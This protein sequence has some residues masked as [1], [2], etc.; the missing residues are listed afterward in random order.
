MLHIQLKIYECLFFDE[1]AEIPDDEPIG[2]CSM[3]KKFNDSSQ[4]TLT[5][6]DQCYLVVL[7]YTEVYCR[8]K[9]RIFNALTGG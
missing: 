8:Y 2:E 1:L 5:P 6:C 7:N 3:D 9:V 4:L